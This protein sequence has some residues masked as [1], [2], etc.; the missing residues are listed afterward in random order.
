L[1]G[2]K[3]VSLTEVKKRKGG[4][5]RRKGSTVSKQFATGGDKNSKENSKKRKLTEETVYSRKGKMLQQTRK[6]WGKLKERLKTLSKVKEYIDWV[7]FSV[8]G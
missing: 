4:G 1:D 7:T 3:K 5:I 2:F 8:G 6:Q